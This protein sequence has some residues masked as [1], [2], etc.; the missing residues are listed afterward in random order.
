MCQIIFALTMKLRQTNKIIAD[1]NIMYAVNPLAASPAP[2]SNILNKIYTAVLLMVSLKQI[3]F[4]K[5]MDKENK[6]HRSTK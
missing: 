5:E 3:A 6:N 4:L 2:V 1:E